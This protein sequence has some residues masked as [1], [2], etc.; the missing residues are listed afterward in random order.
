M[1]TSIGGCSAGIV[2]GG[3]G[4]APTGLAGGGFAAAF[5]EPELDGF[6]LMDSGSGAVRRV[7]GIG[8]SGKSLTS[9]MNGASFG[10]RFPS[11]SG[12]G[13]MA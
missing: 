10:T 7:G 12:L 4:V 5:G 3:G 8:G 2:I 9:K 11:E 1:S 6:D 13:V